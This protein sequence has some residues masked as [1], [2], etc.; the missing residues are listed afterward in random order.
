MIKHKKSY[1]QT[2]IDEYRV[3]AHETLQNT[4][5]EQNFN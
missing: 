1:G 2:N 3:V 5:S 4:I